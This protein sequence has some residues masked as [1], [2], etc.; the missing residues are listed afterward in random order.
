VADDLVYRGKAQGRGRV[1]ME[2][3]SESMEKE[4]ED[5]PITKKRAL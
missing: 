3:W 5:T 4:R 1:L 2:T